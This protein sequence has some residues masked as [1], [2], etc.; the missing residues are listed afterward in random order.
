MK[1]KDVVLR[2]DFAP[3]ERPTV[4]LCLTLQDVPPGALLNVVPYLARIAPHVD[5]TIVTVVDDREFA[6]YLSRSPETVASLDMPV[7]VV[8]VCAAE[9]PHLYADDVPAT[10]V[11]GEPLAD[12]SYPIDDCT[13][14]KFLNDASAAASLG[15]SRCGHDW[16]LTLENFSSLRDPESLAGVCAELRSL[17]KDLAYSL[18]LHLD[19]RSSISPI[20]ASNMPHLNWE[21]PAFAGVEGASSPTIL[22]SNLTVVSTSDLRSA[23]LRKSAFR[24]LYADARSKNWAVPPVNLLHM[25]RTS[26]LTTLRGFARS[27]IDAYLNI[28]L[29]PEERA[30]A[31]SLCGEICEQEG[32]FGEASDWHSRSV[33]EYPAVKNHLRLSRSRFRECQWSECVSAYEA[34][35]EHTGRV[36]LCDDGSETFDK[37]LIMVAVSL[38]KL[39]RSADASRAYQHLRLVFPDNESVKKLCEVGS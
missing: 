14:Q 8:S 24:A 4:S 26:Y 22:E 19:G 36:H 9:Y 33:D 5:E 27:A 28:S 35:A 23:R 7:S 13:G 30:W 39:G 12:E 16:R 10:F 15:W 32:R 11:S 31:C 1:T 38:S 37:S 6:E 21:G 18:H 34:A 25:A 17:Q 3:G 29:Y 2:S 20:L